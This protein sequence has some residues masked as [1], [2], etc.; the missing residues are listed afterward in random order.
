MLLPQV[1]SGGE[2]DIVF[3]VQVPSGSSIYVGSQKTGDVHKYEIFGFFSEYLMHV[4]DIDTLNFLSIFYV[5]LWCLHQQKSRCINEFAHVHLCI[6]IGRGAWH[7]TKIYYDYLQLPEAR[8]V[9][10]SCS[11][12]LFISLIITVVKRCKNNKL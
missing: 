3:T 4:I 8:L 2:L 10:T 9:L 5:G 11:W 12:L 1:L 7:E 6:L